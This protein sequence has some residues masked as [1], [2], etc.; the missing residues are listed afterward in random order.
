M[1]L[2]SNS[3]S[4]A[5]KGFT[6]IETLVVVSIIVLILALTAP[7]LYSTIKATKLSSSGDSV[8]GFLSEAQQISVSGNVQVEVRFFK[9][10][11]PMSP[12]STFRS[13]QMFK[14]GHQPMSAGGQFTEVSQPVGDL[15]RLSDGIVIV[16]DTANLSPLL[17]GDGFKDVKEGGAGSYSGNSEA[18]YNAIR[19]LPD[20]SC[21]VLSSTTGGAVTLTYPALQQSCITLCE[22]LGKQIAVD[23][24]P[25]NF[26]CIQIDPY[27]GKMRTYRPGQN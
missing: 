22:D 13:M 15:V 10:A 2:S 26:Y 25:L 20:G 14:I 9:Y 3:R 1:K 7:S 8:L 17:P 27:T 24:L 16:N 19:F 11:T 18:K 21:R 23:S 12:V 4:A 6:L 5:I